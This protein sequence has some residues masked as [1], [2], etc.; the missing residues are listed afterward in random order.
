M[1]LGLLRHPV[2]PTSG[3]EQLLQRRR[4]GGRR[5]D[6][7]ATFVGVPPLLHPPSVAGMVARHAEDP[8]A[9]GLSHRDRQ[10]PRRR[11]RAEAPNTVRGDCRRRRRRA[12]CTPLSALGCAARS[13]RQAG[14]QR[15][16]RRR[17]ARAA[18]TCRSERPATR[19]TRGDARRARAAGRAVAAADDLDRGRAQPPGGR[20][21]EGGAPSTGLRPPLPRRGRG[22]RRRGAG[23][24]PSRRC[25]TYAHTRQSKAARNRPRRV[26]DCRRERAARRPGRTPR[27][28][29]AGDASG[30]HGV[31]AARNGCGARLAAGTGAE[32]M[33]ACRVRWMR[34]VARAQSPRLLGRFAAIPTRRRRLRHLVSSPLRR[35]SLLPPGCA[36]RSSTISRES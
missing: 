20:P 34:D 10:C 25:R 5:G 31:L 28:V 26:R 3:I 36:A 11:A 23:P 22:A 33:L 21:G 2:R 8:A 14:R 29:R 30:R 35:Y 7:A 32:R 19:R 18:N 1:V 24:R 15:D 16:D 27:R 4:E 6:P 13:P 12:R 9:V 17:A